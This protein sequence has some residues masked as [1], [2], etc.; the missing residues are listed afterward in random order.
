M[1]AG[2]SLPTLRGLSRFATLRVAMALVIV[3]GAMAG[4]ALL[5]EAMNSGGG[6]VYLADLRQTGTGA[7]GVP[8]LSV[9]GLGR[10]T[11]PAEHAT[12]QLMYAVG[13]NDFLNSPGNP[14]SQE[15][16]PDPSGEAEAAAQPI[17]AAI[18]AAGA[19]ADSVSV[20][21]S[22]GFA[23][24]IYS[25]ISDSVA[26]RIDIVLPRPRQEVV[27]SIIAAA[28]S[29]GYEMNL[30]LSPIGVA[31]GVADCAPLHAAAWEAAV[32]DAEL[33]AAAQAERLGVRIGGVV[34]ASETATG[35]TQARLDA[36]T[37]MGSCTVGEQAAL[38]PYNPIRGAVN[39]PPFDPTLP[40]EAVAVASVT[41]SYAIETE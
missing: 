34:A 14:R 31:Y 24:N 2:S 9:V 23:T 4:L 38:D 40:A 8:S 15:G 39:A 17:V 16:T 18:I 29:A 33:R 35:D 5:A 32:A 37:R 36:E 19:P 13:P 1:P 22:A 25:P 21:I 20:V 30:R 26:F 27:A 41:V 10:A 7:T 28:Q 3:L 12:I 6:T 11:A